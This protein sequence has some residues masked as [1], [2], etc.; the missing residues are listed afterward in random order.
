MGI[1]DLGPQV[2]RDRFGVF[3]ME[4]SLMPISIR[5]ERKDLENVAARPRRRDN[6]TRVQ[7][8]SHAM[9]DPAIEEGNG[10]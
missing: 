7:G 8:N 2:P 4:S 10:S 3:W 1:D 5:I 9:F 6:G